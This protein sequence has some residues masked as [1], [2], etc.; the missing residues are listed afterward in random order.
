MLAALIAPLLLAPCQ[1]LPDEDERAEVEERD[2][3]RAMFEASRAD[4]KD[5]E[6][7]WRKAIDELLKL[8]GAQVKA[9]RI[10]PSAV[11]D[12]HLKKMRAALPS[13]K[14]EWP[15]NLLLEEWEYRW[16]AYRRTKW[17]FEHGKSDR[18]AYVDL[19]IS[20][21][22]AEIQMALRREKPQKK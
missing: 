21:L 4:L 17:L 16:E 14:N 3:A 18:D 20:L 10:P 15:E 11:R 12:L 9:G 8:A 13:R 19:A 6:R 1:G 7:R 22:E 2:E 5:L